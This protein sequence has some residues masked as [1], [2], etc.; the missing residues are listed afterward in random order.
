MQSH[1]N[2]CS[3]EGS[4]FVTILS[5]FI[6]DCILLLLVSITIIQKRNLWS[7]IA[8]LQN[9]TYTETYLLIMYK[10]VYLL[11]MII[12]QSLSLCVD[13]REGIHSQRS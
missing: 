2:T 11:T 8:V 9:A 10:S 12:M 7:E 6:V 1:R 5:Y 3:G 13:Y 4:L